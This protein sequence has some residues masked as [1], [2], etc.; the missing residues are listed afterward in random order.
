M[1]GLQNCLNNKVMTGVCTSVCRTNIDDLLNDAWVDRLIEMGVMYCWFHVYRVVGPESSPDLALTTEQL[2]RVRQFVVDTRVKK[3]IIVIDAYHDGDGKALCPAVTGFTHHIGPG[4][5]I[6]PCPIIQ[7]AKESIHDQRPLKEVF[8]QSAFL[9]DFRELVATHTRAVSFWNA[10]ICWSSL[11]KSTTPK[12]RRNGRPSWWSTTKDGS[13]SFAI[14]AWYGDTGAFVAYRL[15][16]KF[17]FHDYG[18]MVATSTHRAG[19]ILTKWSDEPS[20][21]SRQSRY[22]PSRSESSRSD[23]PL[24]Y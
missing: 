12:I 4:G 8:N 16:K 19:K 18:A 3:P 7:L 5:D 17:A 21:L 11:P 2:R 15:A 6:E 20:D 22:D 14:C 24:F 9:K 23:A 10:P 13:P 1:E